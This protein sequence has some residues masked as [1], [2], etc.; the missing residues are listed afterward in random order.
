MIDIETL[1]FTG[2][3]GRGKKRRLLSDSENQSNQEDFI[4]DCFVGK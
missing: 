3:K 1:C 4:K 2:E